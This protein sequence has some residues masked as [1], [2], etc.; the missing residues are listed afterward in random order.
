MSAIDS[1]LEISAF[2]VWI[3]GASA[4]ISTLCVTL[5]SWSLICGR[6]VSR[7]AST[8]MLRMVAV[9]KPLACTERS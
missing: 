8:A 4:T 1:T 3:A 5:A 9:T 6:S 2:S 7:A